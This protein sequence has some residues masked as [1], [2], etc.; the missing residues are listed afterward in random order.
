MT[1]TDYVYSDSSYFS[2]STI[3]NM[4]FKNSTSTSRDKDKYLLASRSVYLENSSYCYFCVRSVN[5]GGVSSK[6]VCDSY[7]Y[8]DSPFYNIVPVVSLKS[9]ILTTGQDESGVWQLKV[10]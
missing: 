10:E 8:G 6:E 4:I 1:Q 7:G 9:N 3:Y 5:G 2:N